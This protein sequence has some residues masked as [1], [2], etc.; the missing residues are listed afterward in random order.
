MPRANGPECG[1]KAN[2]ASTPEAAFAQRRD[3]RRVPMRER[4][5]GVQ[6]AVAQRVMRAFDRLAAR[7][8][9]A[10]DA[11]DEQ[12][13]LDEPERQQ[14]HGGQQRWRWRS[15]PDARRAASS[16]VFRCSG[17]AQV[18]SASAMRR[19]VRVLVHRLVRFGR[20]SS[21]SPRRCRRRAASCPRLPP[22]SAASRSARRK[23]HAARRRTPRDC[24]SSAISARSPPAT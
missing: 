1:T 17:T 3:F 23:R 2:S 22:S 15:S 9:A 11:A 21:D 8:G 7:A 13:R 5:V 18:N 14:R 16:S 10:G 24:G 6:V 19:A 4:V 12:R 20:G